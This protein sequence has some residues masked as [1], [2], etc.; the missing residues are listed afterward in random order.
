VT[1]CCLWRH[2]IGFQHRRSQSDDLGPNGADNKTAVSQ[3]APKR[4]LTREIA[5]DVQNE[6]IAG[7]KDAPMRGSENRRQISVLIA[8]MEACLRRNPKCFGLRR[9][10]R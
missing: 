7:T 5:L 1:S 6:A 2:A 4:T 10:Y 3:C 9:L 8:P